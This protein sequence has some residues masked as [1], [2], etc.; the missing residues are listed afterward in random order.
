MEKH[1]KFSKKWQLHFE[2]IALWCTPL[3]AKVC[4]LLTV[5]LV[6]VLLEGDISTSSS[7][8]LTITATSPDVTNGIL[9]ALFTL[10]AVIAYLYWWLRLVGYISK[11]TKENQKELESIKARE[12]GVLIEEA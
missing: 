4:F 3:V 5:I 8:S 6:N 1:F 9:S 10:M 12:K 11:K 7:G 2:N